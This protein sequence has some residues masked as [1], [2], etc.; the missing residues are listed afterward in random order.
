VQHGELY[1]HDLRSGNRRQ[2]LRGFGRVSEPRW[3]R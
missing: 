3:M 2:L 1:V